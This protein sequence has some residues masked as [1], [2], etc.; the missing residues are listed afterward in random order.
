[1]LGSNDPLEMA[2]KFLELSGNA[3]S[4]ATLRRSG[5][6]PLLVQMMHAPDN[7]QEVRKC[8]GQALHNVVHSHPDEKSGRRE[9]K[10]LRLC[11]CLMAFGSIII[12]IHRLFSPSPL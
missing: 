2:K 1:M 3:Q 7:D 11:L 12:I 4:C 10:V 9:A 8:A 6:M 5:C